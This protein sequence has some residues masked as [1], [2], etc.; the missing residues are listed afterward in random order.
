MLMLTATGLG[1]VLPTL[2]GLGVDAIVLEGSIGRLP[3]SFCYGAT[4][5]IV[6]ERG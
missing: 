4:R 1:L 3:H 2:V 5:I 6:L